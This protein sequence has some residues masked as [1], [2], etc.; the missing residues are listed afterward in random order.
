MAREHDR[1][2]T[3]R[4]GLRGPLSMLYNRYVNTLISLEQAL[5][6]TSIPRSRE[7]VTLSRMLEKVSST[8]RQFPFLPRVYEKPREK[9]S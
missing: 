2:P 4:R 5:T 6:D 7:H 1:I 8:V 3:K 9:N